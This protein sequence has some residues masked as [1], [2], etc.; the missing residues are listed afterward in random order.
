MAIFVDIPPFITDL[1]GG[2]PFVEVTNGFEGWRDDEFSSIADETPS[3]SG[4]DL[5]TTVTELVANAVELCRKDRVSA[6]VL[7]SVLADDTE[8]RPTFSKIACIVEF[9]I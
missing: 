3:S 6:A 9:Q 8:R 2:E 1:Y 4:Q 5:C 7:K